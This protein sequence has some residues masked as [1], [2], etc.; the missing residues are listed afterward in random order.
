MSLV[1]DLGRALAQLGDP[2]FRRVLWRSLGLERAEEAGGVSARLDGLG[3]LACLKKLEEAERT[4][5]EVI[6]P[7]E[8]PTF[9]RAVRASD[10]R[11]K[12]HGARF[13]FGLSGEAEIEA[14]CYEN[15]D[16]FDAELVSPDCGN[17]PLQIVRRANE[18]GRMCRGDMVRRQ[19]RAIHLSAQRSGQSI[20]HRE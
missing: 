1:V 18:G 12:V 2:R 20:E 14:G 10:L 6:W 7:P 13:W 11:V 3:A 8:R 16:T 5:L 19:A 9:A 4:G 15:A 17:L